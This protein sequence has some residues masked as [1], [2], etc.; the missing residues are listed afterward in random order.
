MMASPIS[1]MAS[2]YDL[3]TC[4]LSANQLFDPVYI[5]QELRGTR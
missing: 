4:L 2:T 1:S 3:W 5:H